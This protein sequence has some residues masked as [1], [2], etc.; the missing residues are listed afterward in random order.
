MPTRAVVLPATPLLVPG[1][2]GH[3][4][5]LTAVR[6]AVSRALAAVRGPHGGPPDR[7]GVL[8]PASRSSAGTRRP[9]LAAA[10]VADCWLPGRLI[11]A[12]VPTAQVPAS[13][14]LLTLAAVV[15]EQAA[16][17]AHV[18]QLAGDDHAAVGY[19]LGELSGLDALVVAGG[20]P[21][22]AAA[23]P[24]A[25]APAVR[26]VLDELAARH[27]WTA[28]VRVVA[29]PGGGHLPDAYDVVTWGD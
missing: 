11:A 27:G 22:D 13:V 9:S 3:A 1:A 12:G 4:R 6:A 16:R 21:E 17:R 24:T 15:G 7:W 2:A 20:D 26:G 28:T 8:A 14:A 18:V 29:E 25:C 23:G 19:G 5:P 10:G